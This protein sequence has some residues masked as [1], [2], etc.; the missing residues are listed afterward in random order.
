MNV[1]LKWYVNNLQVVLIE[2]IRKNT[3]EFDPE[4]SL[5][6]A[7]YFL[8]TKKKQYLFFLTSIFLMSG[9]QV[10]RPPVHAVP[11]TSSRSGLPGLLHCARLP[12]GCRPGYGLPS[13]VQTGIE[14]SVFARVLLASSCHHFFSNWGTAFGW[15]PRQRSLSS[16]ITALH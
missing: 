11:A 2:S 1:L 3:Y 13:S 5:N 8:Y 15:L 12:A 9:F 6:L 7:H 16:G 4:K 10:Y 14:P